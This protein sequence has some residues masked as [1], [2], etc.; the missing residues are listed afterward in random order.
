MF[1]FIQ[2]YIA[3]SYFVE[4]YT[5]YLAYLFSGNFGFRKRSS[6]PQ[7][8]VFLWV[9]PVPRGDSSRIILQIF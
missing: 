5:M 2:F 7:P 3:D 6:H 8:I 1:I 9:P 4:L